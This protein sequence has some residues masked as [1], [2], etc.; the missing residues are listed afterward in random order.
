MQFARRKKKHLYEKNL[1]LTSL[2]LFNIIIIIINIII[3]I[4]LKL[5]LN[6]LYKQMNWK[7]R[8]EIYE[9]NIA[10]A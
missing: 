8:Q 2:N 5:L 9:E 6:L 10:N 1:F 4:G 3:L 7:K